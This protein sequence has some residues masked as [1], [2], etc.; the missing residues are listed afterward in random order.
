LTAVRYPM[1]IR[2]TVLILACLLPL[3]PA[4]SEVLLRWTQDSVP[5]SASTGIKTLVVA[6]N[7]DTLIRNARRLGYRTYGEVSVADAPAAAGAKSKKALAGIILNPANSKPEQV[8]QSLRELRTA[9]RDLPVLVLNP[10]AK[11]PQ[12]KGQLV[13]K[14][15]GVLQVTSATAQPWLDTNLALVRLDEAFRPSQAPLYEFQWD[16]SD[17][18]LQKRGPEVADYELAIAEAEAFHADLV[19]DLHSAL[20]ADLLQNKAPEWAQVR[21]YSVFYSQPARK[22]IEPEANIGVVTDDPRSSYEPLNLLARHN[23]PFR[24]L[25]NSELKP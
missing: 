5:P 24:V 16:L 2:K 23:L 19:L 25:R 7:A 6:W 8:E 18:M 17:P 11:Q 22:G 15:N 21:R 13:I 10:A 3:T 4:W 20:Q 1:F 12:M 9:Y 14:S